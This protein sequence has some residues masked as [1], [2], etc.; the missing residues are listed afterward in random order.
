MV[1]DLAPRRS[2]KVTEL[3][4]SSACATRAYAK[5]LVEPRPAVIVTRWRAMF[6]L[7]CSIARRFVSAFRR[8]DLAKLGLVGSVVP[9]PVEQIGDHAPRSWFLRLS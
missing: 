9:Y 6:Q 8:N 2:S 3:S 7:M 1:A 5:E 4:E